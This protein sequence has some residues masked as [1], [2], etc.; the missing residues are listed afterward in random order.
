MSDY[1]YFQIGS[2]V[3][4]MAGPV[5]EFQDRDGGWQPSILPRDM[6]LDEADGFGCELFGDAIAEAVSG[7]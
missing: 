5:V 3:W 2:D 6:F 7:L 1:R 4:R